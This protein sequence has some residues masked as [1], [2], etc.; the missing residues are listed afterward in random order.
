MGPNAIP[1]LD[2]LCDQ[3]ESGQSGLFT[4]YLSIYF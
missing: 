4:L 1:S 2:R 3:T